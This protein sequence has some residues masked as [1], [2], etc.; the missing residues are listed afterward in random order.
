MTD[1]PHW[2]EADPARLEHEREENE[3]QGLNFT[4]DR[5]LFDSARVVSFKGSVTLSG[6]GVRRFEVVYPP[7]FPFMRPEVY[8][9]DTSL[10]RHQNPL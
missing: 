7:A 5:E 8:S 9:H 6:G 3:R 10:E 1:F 2:F 4:L